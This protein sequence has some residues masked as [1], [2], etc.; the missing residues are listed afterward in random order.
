MPCLV[1]SRW[2]RKIQRMPEDHAILYMQTVRRGRFLFG[3]AGDGEAAGGVRS[4]VI[5]GFSCLI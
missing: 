2:K 3:G 1:L 5:P 4:Q